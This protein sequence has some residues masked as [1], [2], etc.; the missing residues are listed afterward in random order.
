MRGQSAI[1]TT[2][3]T[4]DASRI[5]GDLAVFGIETTAMMEECVPISG[6][7]FSPGVSDGDIAGG[8]LPTWVSAIG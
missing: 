7:P 5:A 4:M 8:G 2:L 1:V 6:R 3:P